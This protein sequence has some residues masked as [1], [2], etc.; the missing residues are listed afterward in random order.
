MKQKI[1]VYITTLLGYTLLLSLLLF[2]VREVNVFK[3]LEKIKFLPLYT[4]FNGLVFTLIFSFFHKKHAQSNLQKRILNTIFIYVS[5]IITGVVFSGVLNA[6]LL[7]VLT[8]ISTDRL[9]NNLYTVFSL[10][11]VAVIMLW[12]VVL[13]FGFITFGFLEILSHLFINEKEEKKSSTKKNFIYVAS[14]VIA[15]VSLCFFVLKP[16]YRYYKIQDIPNTDLKAVIYTQKN[17]NTISLRGEWFYTPA[18]VE[19]QDLQGNIIAKQI[20]F[21]RCTVQVGEIYFKVKNNKLYY[22]KFSY[23]DLS[24]YSYYCFK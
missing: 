13:I 21:N 11:I 24:D 10:L 14:I 1:K 7:F 17:Y 4:V 6:I 9:L 18:Y 2:I 15:S 16:K 19:L 8:E 5:F 12:Y 20:F 3:A 22:T 23:I